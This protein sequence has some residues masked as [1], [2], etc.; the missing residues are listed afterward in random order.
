MSNHKSHGKDKKKGSQLVIRVDKSE[1]DDFVTLCEQLDT[2]AA[3]EIRRFMRE[4]VTARSEKD[5][6]PSGETETAVLADTIDVDP[7]SGAALSQQD[8][9]QGKIP[10]GEAKKPKKKP[11]RTLQQA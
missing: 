2:S 7:M 8:D 1:R 5:T 3:R 10:G 6:E 4:F 9:A 11:K